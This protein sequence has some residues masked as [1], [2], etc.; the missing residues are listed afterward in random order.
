MNTEDSNLQV[1]HI[2]NSSSDK[3]SNQNKIDKGK[4][5]SNT[6]NSPGSSNEEIVN[7]NNSSSK[8]S[9]IKSE[10]KRPK[11]KIFIPEVNGLD[12]NIDSV[13]KNLKL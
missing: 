1:N 13:K 6:F 12:S 5:N 8:E 7:N 3:N 10:N 11:H 4:S 2:N 9:N